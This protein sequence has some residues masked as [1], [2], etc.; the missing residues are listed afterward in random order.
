M[1]N[2]MRHCAIGRLVWVDPVNCMMQIAPL[3][4][5]APLLASLSPARVNGPATWR[6]GAMVSYRERYH[7]AHRVAYDVSPAPANLA[8]LPVCED[9][10][11]RLAG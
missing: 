3:D 5:T 4:R 6:V 8:I 11:A 7:V 1:A 9:R 2:T 10:G